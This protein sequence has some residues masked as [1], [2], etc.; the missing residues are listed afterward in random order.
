MNYTLKRLLKNN[1]NGLKYSDYIETHEFKRILTREKKSNENA[2]YLTLR[3][4]TRTP[5]SYSERAIKRIT[6]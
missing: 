5:I 6:Y 1:C 2:I 4:V 3:E